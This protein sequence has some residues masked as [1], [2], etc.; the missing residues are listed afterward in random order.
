QPLTMITGRTALGVFLAGSFFSAVAAAAV[1]LQMELDGRTFLV[2]EPR[3]QRSDASL[4]AQYPPNLLAVPRPAP[5]VGLGGGAVFAA[6]AVAVGV[7]WPRRGEPYLLDLTA[8]LSGAAAGA[9]LGLAVSQFE[10]RSNR[11]WQVLLLTVGPAAGAALG[12][13]NGLF[14]GRGLRS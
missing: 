10:W 11:N 2:G 14:V 4:N 6:L 1:A 12:L 5:R 3:G 7:V 13:L 8:A 9:A